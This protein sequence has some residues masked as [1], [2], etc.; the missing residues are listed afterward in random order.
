MDYSGVLIFRNEFASLRLIIHGEGSAA[1]SDFYSRKRRKGYGSSLLKEVISFADQ[2][3]LFLL[4]E[5][6]PYGPGKN[7][8]NTHLVK[9]YERFGFK[10]H[11]IGRKPTQLMIR[12]SGG[13]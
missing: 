8:D 11:S 13:A 6:R 7:N 5:A 10:V 3:N 1:I 9:L 2:N 12:K 4:L